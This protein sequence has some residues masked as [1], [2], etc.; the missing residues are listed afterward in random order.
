MSITVIK[1]GLLSTV[2]DLG[3]YGHQH[4]GVSPG[5]AMD[6]RA[7][8][9][10]NLIAGNSDDQASLEVT[11]SGPVLRFDA[12]C[13]IAISGATLSPTLNDKPVP[14]N[15][16]LVVRAGDTLAFGARKAGVRAYVAVHGGLDIAP[17]MGS[18]S[19][20]LRG[21]FGG[22]DGRALKKG[23]VL[24]LRKRIQ[25]D[26]DA[27]LEA[28]AQGL[29]GIV[30][31]LPA[32]LGFMPRNDIR[33]IPG[34]HDGLFTPASIQKFLASEYIVDTRSDRMGYRLDGPALSFSEPVQLLSE[35]TSFGT[36]QVPQDGMPIVLMA[37][38]QTT[39]GYAKFAHVISVDL[40]LLAQIMPGEAIRFHTVD[41][42]TAER[43]DL[44]R[45]EAFNRL[46]Q[47]LP[48]VRRLLEQACADRETPTAAR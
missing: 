17:V 21:G 3:R 12:A 23:D 24:P 9:L 16:P 46:S 32:V 28:L 38:R 6:G 15:R 10:A 2:Q 37:D 40:P 44:Q 45:E 31:Y 13:G 1:P 5:G 43:L 18:R 41:L 11:L 48:E 19:T 35:V 33:I 47:H 36:I 8:R 20:Y 34:P 22:L 25:P 4:L 29:W 30:L 14:N 27:A 7:H 39:G 26:D 42:E